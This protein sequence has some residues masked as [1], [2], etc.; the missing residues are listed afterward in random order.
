MVQPDPAHE[1][2]ES[3]DGLAQGDAALPGRGMS[4]REKA[5][6]SLRNSKASIFVAIL[7]VILLGRTRLISPDLTPL[8]I[9]LA[10]LAIW[11]ISWFKKVGWSDLGIYQPKSWIRIILI[12]IGTAI[13]FQVLALVQ[14][15]L[16]GPTPDL[17]SFEQVKNNPWI[18]LMFLVVSWT[19]AG[20]GEEVIWRGFI[21]KQLARIF[22]EERTGWALGLILSAA[23]FGLIH[24][25]Q[26]ITGI[27]MTALTGVIYGLI[28]LSSGKNLWASIFAHAFTDT[29]SF[30]LLFYW[31]KISFLYKVWDIL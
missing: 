13:L 11:I 22:G 12:G 23:I 21:M 1:K 9:P 8:G 17:S 26:G 5:G 24:Y 16:G 20:F 7:V 4:F 29:T 27:L 30:L 10:L 3:S 31:D 19:T 6:Q 15:K 28:F 25:Y 14:I 2:S 18:L